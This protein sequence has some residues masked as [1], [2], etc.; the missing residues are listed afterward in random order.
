M[1]ICIYLPVRVKGVSV[2]Q[3]LKEKI[4]LRSGQRRGTGAREEIALGT[5][6]AG[7]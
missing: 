2:V 3:V 1:S 5:C 4:S 6:E 7:M